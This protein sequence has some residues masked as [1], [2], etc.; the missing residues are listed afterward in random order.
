MSIGVHFIRFLPIV[1]AGRACRGNLSLR[2]EDAAR[3]RIRLTEVRK[4]FPGSSKLF[5]GRPM[6][7][8]PLDLE[9]E[10]S[11]PVSCR[12]GIFYLYLDANGRAFPCNNLQVESLRCDMD[13][14]R[15]QSL[16]D[17]WFHSP[18]L[19]QFR[20]P[21]EDS[22]S[23]ACT[24]CNVRAECVGECRAFCWY[25]YGKLDLSTKP[26]PCYREISYCED[27]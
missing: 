19:K 17:I 16:F 20:R 13:T 14:V 15:R 3:A 6:I 18:T 25:R 9:I 27:T 8:S 1:P 24:D 12:A 11:R 26:S 2:G 23:P 22:L 21:R 7:D 4:R 5:S 10:P